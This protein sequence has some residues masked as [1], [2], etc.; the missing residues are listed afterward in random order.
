MEIK[1]SRINNGYKNAVVYSLIH[2][3]LLLINAVSNDMYFQ[4]NICNFYWLS[5]QLL[6]SNTYL[7][8]LCKCL[9]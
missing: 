6:L 7:Q 1:V 5:S 9:I 3:H 8:V 4:K 2:N